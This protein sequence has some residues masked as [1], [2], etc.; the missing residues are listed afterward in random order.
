MCNKHFYKPTVNQTISGDFP[1]VMAKKLQRGHP[2]VGTSPTTRKGEVPEVMAKKLP[3]G[4]PMVGTSP[5][6]RKG[7]VPIKKIDNFL[8][9]PFPIHFL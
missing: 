8:R 3:R 6:T 7:E 4:H 5:T 2:M 1:E 9:V